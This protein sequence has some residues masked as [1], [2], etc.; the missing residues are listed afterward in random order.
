MSCMPCTPW[1]SMECPLDAEPEREAGV[2]VGV[3]PA[4]AQHLAVDHAGATELDPA[5]PAAGAARLGA[6]PGLLAVAGEAEEVGLHARLGE[7]EV[8]G[9][10]PGAGLLAEHDAHE[11]VERAAQVGHRQALV[12]GEALDLVEDR[13]VGRVEV[14]GAE[15]LA[16]GHDVD[17]R[18]LLEH[19]ADLHR[20]GLGAQH[21]TGVD[22]VE[23]EGVLHLPGR[24][25]GAEVE[26][27]EVEPL[28]LELGALGDL[29]AHADEGVD[30]ALRGELDRM[31]RAGLA[32]QGRHG[33]I[34]P[35]LDEDALVALHLELCLARRERLRDPGPGLTDALAGLGL[36]ARGQRA[37]LAVREGKGALLTLVGRAHRLQLLEGAGGRG[38]REGLLDGGVD[39][40]GIERRDLDGV[41]VRVGSGHRGAFAALVDRGLG[42]P[43]AERLAQ[44]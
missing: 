18:L 33:D 12:D 43:A 31:A 20:R 13:R 32:T 23:E 30:E 8:V 42:A 19:R 2:D 40:R 39:L 17:R 37:D 9:P 15:H 6:A 1:R 3:D 38:G 36:R 35:L 34:D 44:V 28:A 16:G 11:R 24:V 7:R 10:H 22:G 41:V 5:R 27:I 26:G 14:V 21:E 29:P 25:V 4:R